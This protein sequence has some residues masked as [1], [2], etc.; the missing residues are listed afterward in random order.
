MVEQ[1]QSSLDL[2]FYALSDP[3]RRSML[4]RIA[5]GIPV[6]VSELAEPFDMSLAAVSKHLQVLEKANFIKKTKTG[7]VITCQA[8]L[9]PLGEMM[10]LLEDLGRYWNSKLDSLETFLANDLKKGEKNDRT[11]SSKST[12]ISDGST[13]RKSKKR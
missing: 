6:T 1:L 10:E 5:L 7:R 11:N 12:S 3:T 4:A 13:R 9:E 8:T 2:S